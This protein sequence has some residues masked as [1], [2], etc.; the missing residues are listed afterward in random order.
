MKRRDVDVAWTRACD[1]L[2]LPHVATLWE[3][4]VKLLLREEGSG[5]VMAGDVEEWFSHDVG[6]A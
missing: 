6:P 4:S 1:G 2:G 5:K 3:Q